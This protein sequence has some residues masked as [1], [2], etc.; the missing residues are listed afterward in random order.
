MK[1]LASVVLAAL[2]V[3]CASTQPV[4]VNYAQACAAYGAGFA[5][6]LELRKAGKL[7]QAQIAQI[8]ML[9]AQVTPICTGNLPA[10]SDA[11]TQQVVAAVTTLAVIEAITKGGAQ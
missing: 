2:L 4:Q 9:D 3:G 5:T 11:A 8:S 1:K 7:N 10:D 6:A